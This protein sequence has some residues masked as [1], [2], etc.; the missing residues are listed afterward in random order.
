MRNDAVNFLLRLDETAKALGARW[1]VL[2]NDFRVA[3]EVNT[4]TG[5]CNVGFVG[6]L[7]ASGALNW[8]GPE[9]LK[10]HFHLDLEIPKKVAAPAA[11][12]P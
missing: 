5:S 12:T 10:L 3:D 4:A 7:D 6:G 2:Y 9:G 8:H 1:R 11:P